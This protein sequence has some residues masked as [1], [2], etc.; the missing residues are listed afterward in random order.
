MHPIRCTQSHHGC[1]VKNN[2]QFRTV[3]VRKKVLTL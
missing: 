3:N 2:Y 1:N